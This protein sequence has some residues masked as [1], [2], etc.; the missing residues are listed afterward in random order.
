MQSGSYW[1]Y[2]EAAELPDYDREAPDV[3]TLW[4]KQ[5]TA[6]RP[7]LCDLCGEEIA[8]GTRYRSVGIVMDGEF[9]TQKMHGLGWGA[10]AV[11]PCPKFA[12][13]DR[14][15][16]AEQFEADRQQYFPSDRQP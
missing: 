8:P 7:H 9:A 4:D 16:L 3:R 14:K 15:E 6:R 1:A 10:S 12:E 11:S 2:R 5:H 13:R